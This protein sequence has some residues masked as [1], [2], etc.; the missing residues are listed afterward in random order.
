VRWLHHLIMWGLILFSVSH[1]A[2]ALLTSLVEANGEFDSIFSGCKEITPDE[3][4][5]V[6]AGEAA[7][8]ANS[9][10]R[11]IRWPWQQKRTA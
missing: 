5:E 11:R 6:R 2:T 1:M 10:F 7:D 3:L 8:D 4:R 9:W